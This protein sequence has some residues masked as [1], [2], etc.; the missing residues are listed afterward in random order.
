MDYTPVPKVLIEHGGP[1]EWP[2]AN[3]QRLSFGFA[4]HQLRVEIV[5]HIRRS[6]ADGLAAAAAADDDDDD[7]IVASP[8]VDVHAAGAGADA[9]AAG[10]DDDDDDMVAGP[11][12]DVHAAGLGAGLGHFPRDP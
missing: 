8:G 10:N 2:V 5:S 1:E 3:L 9:G 4:E 11:G 7:D 6:G 12:I